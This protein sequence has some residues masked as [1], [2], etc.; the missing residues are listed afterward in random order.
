MFTHLATTANIKC[1]SKTTATQA[2]SQ[3]PSEE[4][5]YPG[6]DGPQVCPAYPENKFTV[7]YVTDIS[8]T[9]QAQGSQVVETV[10]S[11]VSAEGY[12]LRIGTQDGYCLKSTQFCTQAGPNY[13][14][15]H[16]GTTKYEKTTDTENK[17]I[18]IS[19]TSKWSEQSQANAGGKPC[20]FS[21]ANP[22]TGSET[23]TQKANPIGVVESACKINQVF[24]TTKNATHNFF[25]FPTKTDK[26]FSLGTI[27]CKTPS[28]TT[29]TGTESDAN[30]FVTFFTTSKAAPSPT[31]YLYYNTRLVW[32]SVAMPPD[33]VEQGPPWGVSL[34]TQQTGTGTGTAYV[35]VGSARI[36]PNPGL[37]WPNG[38]FLRTPNTLWSFAGGFNSMKSF[39]SF[40]PP[41]G[42][43]ANT[44]CQET[45]S[46]AGGS[47]Y[48]VPALS[49]TKTSET[50]KCGETKSAVTTITQYFSPRSLTFKVEAYRQRFETP[51]Y[52]IPK[53]L[54][55][56]GQSGAETELIYP[57]GTSANFLD[58]RF[59][60]ICAA[61]VAYPYLHTYPE[62]FTVQTKTTTFSGKKS[63]TKTTSVAF[64]STWASSGMSTFSSS[65]LK[66]GKT[67]TFATSKTSTFPWKIGFPPAALVGTSAAGSLK[68]TVYWAKYKVSGSSSL[69][70]P[71]AT[72][73]C[74]T[75]NSA[76]QGFGPHPDLYVF[77]N[78]FVGYG[79]AILGPLWP[80][81]KSCSEVSVTITNDYTKAFGPPG[82]QTVKTITTEAASILMATWQNK[83]TY[84]HSYFSNFSTKAFSTTKT[85]LKATDKY[86]AILDATNYTA[87]AHVVATGSFPIV[88]RGF[89]WFD[90][91]Q[92]VLRHTLFTL[93]RITKKFSITKTQSFWST[94]QYFHA[95]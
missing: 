81:G 68:E 37:G 25:G 44:Y 64:D 46:C 63:G 33:S 38:E 60:N 54:E 17:E 47:I 45:K 3:G 27:T 78:N 89:E 50:T 36:F 6:P 40:S 87:D 77:P 88:R 13:K 91:P 51:L 58:L 74:F 82:S 55:G 9:L 28:A 14:G 4:F 20:A 12:K 18:G 67:I 22:N 56:E 41:T 85:T 59:F 48:K 57:A 73:H 66:D 24:Y 32:K 11:K 86:S 30:S 75:Q 94:W 65:K 31:A 84:K 80:N 95:I 21:W 53:G 7:T 8:Y 90:S 69:V 23:G 19:V 79:T 61:G 83:K 70:E 34:K 72:V 2:F 29:K 35:A 92:N 42:T 5:Q 76:N 16:Y 39:Q 71:V 52:S 49:S 1:L 62:S 26:L 15:T 93:P 10:Q 43:F